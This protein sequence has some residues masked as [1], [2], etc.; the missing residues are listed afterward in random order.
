MTT[1][2]ELRK[3][4]DLV[5]MAAAE[6][7]FTFEP[8]NNFRAKTPAQKALAIL[9][10]MIQRG[11]DDA[12]P[13]QDTPDEFSEAIEAARGL[14]TPEGRETY[15][16]AFRLVSNRH[17]KFALVHLVNWLLKHTPPAEPTEDEFL[18]ALQST[19]NNH[20]ETSM[21]TP[22]IARRIRAA[23]T[24]AGLTVKKAA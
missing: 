14:D 19:I 12:A 21:S 18:A 24:T 4:R 1:T 10:D 11:V 17:S 3:V 7:K 22:E 23:L 13:W 15:N 16:L 20:W 2:D 8:P 5:S 6:K 9:D